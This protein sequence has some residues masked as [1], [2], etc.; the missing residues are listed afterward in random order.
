M[1]AKKHIVIDARIRRSSTGRYVARLLDHLQTIDTFHRYTVLV[2]PDDDWQPEASNFHALPCP[3]AQFSFNPLE[4]IGFYRQ[5]KRLKPDL[6]HFT[7]TQQPLPYF[8]TIVTT[9]HD[10]TMF[11]FVRRGNTPKPIFWLKMKLYRFLFI[12]SH[13]KS[14]KIIVPTNFVAADLANYQPSAKNKI[15][16]TYEAGD[17]PLKAQAKRPASVKSSDKYIMYV[18]TCFPHKN[19]KRLVDAFDILKKQHPGLKL[20]FVGKRDIHSEELEQYA[21]SHTSFPDIIFTGFT[22]NEEL[23][24]LFEHCQAYVFP[25]LSEGFGLPGIE[26][27]IH[28]APVASSNASC[29]PEVYGDA[30]HYF[31]PQSSKDM[32]K[33]ISE[34]ISDPKLQKTLKENATLQ[35]KKYS[36]HRM[37]EET[38]IV[39][40]ELLNE[41][42]K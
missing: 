10:L 32:A 29:L 33:K 40:K 42:V 23:K 12:W 7:M 36:W 16:V 4:Q 25:S 14:D 26:A 11:H 20:V 24:W 9:T 13:I 18:G 17:L 31:N 8:G 19:L 21:A 30:A 3:Y 39:Y 37:A 35:V 28:G 41:T 5:L 34:V 1:P 38:L 27:M 6:V 15:V 2:Q 22:S